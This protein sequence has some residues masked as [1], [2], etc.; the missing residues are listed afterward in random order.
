MRLLTV[1]LLSFILMTPS[2]ADASVKNAL[3]VSGKQR[4]L[5]QKMSKEILLI[6]LGISPEKNGE[7]LLKTSD[8]FNR[9]LTDLVVGNPDRGLDSVIT[10][11]AFDRFMDVLNIWDN[12]YY[13]SRTVGQS[14]KVNHDFI[15]Y[16]SKKNMPLLKESN[17]AVQAISAAAGA[18][19]MSPSLANTINLAGRQRMLSQKMAKEFLFILTG[20]DVSKYRAELKKTYSL[21][22]TTHNRLIN[23]SSAHKIVAPP[24][25]AVANQLAKVDGVWES[26]R[27]AI[28]R[29]ASGQKISTTDKN[30]VV[31]SN[32]TLLKEMNKAVGMYSN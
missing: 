20:H 3:N 1:A 4:M 7:N 30:I 6:Y 31:N 16:L 23:G 17:A 21:F 15:I 13:L 5:T 26:M 12:F 24:S 8:L 28:S 11:E 27:Y 2:I 10:P 19:T 22:N 32:L 14:K 9:N 25:E 18:S 29:A